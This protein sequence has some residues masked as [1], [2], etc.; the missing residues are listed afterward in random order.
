MWELLPITESKLP[1]SR[2]MIL[3]CS[4]REPSL[5]LSWTDITPFVRRRNVIRL[6][7]ETDQF[8]LSCVEPTTF[9]RWLDG[10]FAALAIAHPLDERDF[11]VDH[12]VPRS[13]RS[14]WLRAQRQLT[15]TRPR[16][17]VPT[18]RPLSQLWL[19]ESI[20]PR[21]D[22]SEH[23]VGI[24]GAL[25]ELNATSSDSGRPYSMSLSSSLLSLSHDIDLDADPWPNSE[26]QSPGLGQA[27]NP[28]SLVR[29]SSSVSPAPSSATTPTSPLSRTP[30]ARRPANRRST[31]ATPPYRP[32]TSAA[33][34]PAELTRPQTS[35]VDRPPSSHPEA[36]KWKPHHDTPPPEADLRHGRLCFAILLF[37]SPRK[38]N[39]IVKR[40]TKWFVDW[41]TGRMVR[42]LPPTYAEIDRMEFERQTRRTTHRLGVGVTM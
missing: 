28:A 17:P 30:S 27:G 19:E 6:R 1:T 20:T 34:P 11:P 41:E 12:S 14:R 39:Y 3:C 29:S 4:H 8:L 21:N 32:P 5:A 25:A 26:P 37:G 31:T 36:G 24:F 13:Q 35:D 42:V 18:P 2:L 33:T 38:S 40:Q 15:P 16:Y 10:L 23:S 7:V 22:G 9:A